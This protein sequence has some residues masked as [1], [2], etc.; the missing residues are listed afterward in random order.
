[1]NA[2]A[3]TSGQRTCATW[4]DLMKIIVEDYHDSLRAT[5]PRLEQLA[6][7]IAGEHRAPIHVLDPLLREF[8]ALADSLRAHLLQQEGRL[9]P[10]IRHV[11]GSA[12]GLAWPCH[13]DESLEKLMDEATR[14]DREEVA[15]AK[16]AEQA[17][18]GMDGMRS[19]LLV[20][21]L[22]KG[23]HELRQDLEE[24][25]KLET[26]VLFPIV[27]EVLR[28][29]LP[30]SKKGSGLFSDFPYGSGEPESETTLD[31][32]SESLKS[33]LHALRDRLSVDKAIA[34][35]SRLPRDVRRLYYADWQ[36]RWDHATK[37]QSG[38]FLREIA[39]A[40]RDEPDRG[41]EDIA[42]TV[43]GALA[44]RLPARDIEAVM[45]MLP[46]DIRSLWPA[47]GSPSAMTELIT[48]D[49]ETG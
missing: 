23:I 31:R 42:R 6:E 24:H 9:F 11:C 34:L 33:V 43:F 21:K 1:M 3:D 44:Q 15:S 25:V 5:L 41:P 7:R 35:G 46:G 4:R 26:N 10:M 45:A 16:R 14:D 19:E 18:Q 47:E 17:F 39:N 30:N 29:H 48:P 40:H 12:E 49:Q 28:R 8:S 38:D 2:V 36:H 27:K 32:F 20:A 22:V 13:L 37:L